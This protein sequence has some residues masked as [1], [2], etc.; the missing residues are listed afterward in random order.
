[1]GKDAFILIVPTIAIVAGVFLQ[2][3]NK[4]KIAKT[5]PDEELIN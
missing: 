3:K 2:K 4:I 5:N 1:L